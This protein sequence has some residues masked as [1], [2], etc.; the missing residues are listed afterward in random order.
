M[1]VLTR[2]SVRLA[3]NVVLARGEASTDHDLLASYGLDD[4]NLAA[5]VANGW[6]KGPTWAELTSGSL[7]ESQ[8][9]YTLTASGRE[10]LRR[11]PVSAVMRPFVET[12][13]RT[14]Q[15]KAFLREHRGDRQQVTDAH[16]QG[17][18]TVHYAGDL[19]ETNLDDY[20][21]RHSADF[22]VIVTTQGR[23][24]IG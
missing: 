2:E 13:M 22:T 6:L 21:F 10:W 14:M 5:L 8:R 9:R 15:L 3:L 18:V 23:R 17:W 24:A 12:G 20:A 16:A 1:T 11:D 4:I 7:P 19:K